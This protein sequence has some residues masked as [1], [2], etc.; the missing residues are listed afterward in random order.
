MSLPNED[1]QWLDSQSEV[2]TKEMLDSMAFAFS[3]DSQEFQD[4]L[5]YLDDVLNEAIANNKSTSLYP[6]D[7]YRI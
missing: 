4:C 6:S 7:V 2:T 3:P 5:K 1:D